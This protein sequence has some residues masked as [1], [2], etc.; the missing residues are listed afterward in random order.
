M[1]PEDFDNMPLPTWLTEQDAD[2][3]QDVLVL[4]VE[5]WT[6]G[7]VGEPDEDE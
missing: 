2:D 3:P 6:A 7:V 1:N 4:F 5:S